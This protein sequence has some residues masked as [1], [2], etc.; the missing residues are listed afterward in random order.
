MC[1]KRSQPDI[2]NS[3]NPVPGLRAGT[4]ACDCSVSCFSISC[5]RTNE[6]SL[7]DSFNVGHWSRRN[8]ALGIYAIAPVARRAHAILGYAI[9]EESNLNECLLNI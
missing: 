1:D 4:Q 7:I 5:S 6:S 2:P 8:R 3:H 9:F